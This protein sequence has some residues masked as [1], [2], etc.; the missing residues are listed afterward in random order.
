M[1]VRWCGGRVVASLILLC[2]RICLPAW[3]AVAGD[4]RAVLLD[5]GSQLIDRLASSMQLRRGFLVLLL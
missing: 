1:R 2:S 3:Y 4:I 5:N